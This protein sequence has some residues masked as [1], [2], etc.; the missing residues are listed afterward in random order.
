MDQPSRSVVDSSVGYV[1]CVGGCEFVV[2]NDGGELRER[3]RDGN[4]L[5]TLEGMPLTEGGSL[6]V[7]INA[8]D[9]RRYATNG[10]RITGCWNQ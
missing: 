5:G 3:A 7:G 8:W 6:V 9:A 1:E 10:R 2:S 4:M